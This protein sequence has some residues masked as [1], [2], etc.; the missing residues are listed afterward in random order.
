MNRQ[1]DVRLPHDTPM[2]G[3]AGII[4]TERGA[5]HWHDLALM[6][7]TTRS[8]PRVR[9]SHRISECIQAGLHTKDRLAKYGT[10][11]PSIA[12][13]Q[14]LHIS[15]RRMWRAENYAREFN[16][17]VTL[18]AA[19]RVLLGVEN[20]SPAHSVLHLTTSPS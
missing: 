12:L 11:V 8:T 16:V 9:T 4:T 3:I 18:A 19:R 17:V 7:Q 20:D 14:D 6:M 5:D 2:P 15:S 1:G 10:T 13:E